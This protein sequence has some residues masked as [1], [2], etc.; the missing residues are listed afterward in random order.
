VQTRIGDVLQ[1]MYKGDP[2]KLAK[3]QAASKF[4]DEL[5]KQS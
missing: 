1:D 3:I 2:D 5:Q 4:Y